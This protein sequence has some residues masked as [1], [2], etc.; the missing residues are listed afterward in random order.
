MKKTIHKVNECIRAGRL[1]KAREILVK[2]GQKK[3]PR[4]VAL[5]LAALARQTRLLEL[6]IAILHPW[7]DSEPSEAEKFEYASSL[8]GIGATDEAIAILERVDPQVFPAALLLNALTRA[9]QWDYS[10]A[11]PSLKKFVGMTVSSQ[12]KMV[13]KLNLAAALIFEAR[14]EEASP[15][16]D[17]LLEKTAEKKLATLYGTVL[18][19][20]AQHAIFRA[21]WKEA[22]KFLRKAET[23]FEKITGTE[24]FFIRKWKALLML[25]RDGP[26]SEALEG[27]RAFRLEAIS[28]SHWE[29]ARTCDRF[30]AIVC[31]DRALWLYLYFGSPFKS[32]RN[33]LVAE[34]KGDKSIP[35]EYVWHLGGENR[36]PALRLNKAPMLASFLCRDFYRPPRLA[37]LHHLL[38][39]EEP[40]HPRLSPIKTK[41]AIVALMRWFSKQR[42]PL[43]IH[44]QAG[45]YRLEATG[46]CSIRIPSEAGTD[47]LAA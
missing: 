38:Y 16:L 36:A 14:L 21:R 2:V 17:E 34:F 22:E 46:N 32:L 26:T 1:V 7:M 6:S 35:R 3:I 29:T 5:P 25:L 8:A 23:A 41:R 15:L 30:L 9:T 27:V 44:A 20:C 43:A 42:L 13:A 19:L 11:I 47:K 31:E 10:G 40:Y 45:R 18:E 24:F 28:R 33:K 37:S 12:Q 39:P 4:R